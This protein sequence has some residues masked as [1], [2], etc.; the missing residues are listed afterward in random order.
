M[1]QCAPV[2]LARVRFEVVVG[3]LLGGGR[4]TPQ[5]SIVLWTA[6]IAQD[7]E[8]ICRRLLPKG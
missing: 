4:N 6:D 7:A 8:H 1:E 5:M 2:A 3:K